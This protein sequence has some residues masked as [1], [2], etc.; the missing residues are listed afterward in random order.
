MR[1]DLPPSMQQSLCDLSPDTIVTLFRLELADHSAIFLMSPYEEITWQGDEYTSIP[2]KMSEVT[3]D[4][5]GKATRPKFTFVNP[6]GLFTSAIYDRHLDNA[7][8]TRYRILKGDLDDDRNEA[9]TESF[10]VSRVLSVTKNLVVTELRDVL[11]GHVFKIP[12][13]AFYPP[14]FPHVSLG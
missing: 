8:V 14:E 13:R 9:V 2:C 4:A 3:V 6:E 1:T 12:A 7:I 5:D 11:D 10:R